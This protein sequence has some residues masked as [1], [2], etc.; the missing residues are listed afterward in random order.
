[1]FLSILLLLF[2]N[3]KLSYANDTVVFQGGEAG[4]SCIRIPSV[5]TTTRGT[6]IAFGEARMLNCNDNTEKN[7]VSIM[8]RHGRIY[9]FYIEEILQ[10]VG[11]EILY[12]YN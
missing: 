10:I 9:K 7:E 3:I 6:L 5:L 4:Y 8:G 1:M 12:Q 2:I 11:L